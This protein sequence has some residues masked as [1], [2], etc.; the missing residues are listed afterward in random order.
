MKQMFE[1]P[2]AAVTL[3]DEELHFISRAG[4]WACSA[5]RPGARGERMR[6]GKG[7]ARA[8]AGSATALLLACCVPVCGMKPVPWL[9]HASH[10]AQSPQAEAAFPQP[11]VSLEERR[12]PPAPPCR[13]PGRLLRPL[14]PRP[15][16]PSATGSWCRRRPRCSLSRT[17][18][19]MSGAAPPPARLCGHAC[20]LA[21][22]PLTHSQPPPPRAHLRLQVQEQQVC[23][24]RPAHTLLCRRPARLLLPR[25]APLR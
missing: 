16:A 12:L 15:Q 8:P 11:A 6:S 9:R 5:G 13:A 2:V 1:T 17:P 22:L 21:G 25:G 3:I 10:F 14:A 20:L 18:W 4:D 24:G 7:P 23:G 19:K